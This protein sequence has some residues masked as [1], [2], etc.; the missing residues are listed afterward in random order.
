MKRLLKIAGL[1]LLG[2]LLVVGGLVA[3]AFIGSGE[4]PDRRELEGFARIVKDGFVSVAVLDLGDGR[5]ALVDA[6]NDAEGKALRAEL[7]RRGKSPDDV[8]AIL[9][10]HGHPD[11]IAAVRLFS[12]AEI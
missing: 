11:H 3:C 8:A 1:A 7:E 6:G 12:N 9:L 10:T 2:I 4:I 5:L